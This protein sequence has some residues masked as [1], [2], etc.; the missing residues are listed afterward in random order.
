MHILQTGVN[1]EVGRE[2]LLFLLEQGHT[3]LATDVVPLLPDI[4]EKAEK[5]RSGSWKFQLLDC[6]DL[7]AID[8]ILEG[9]QPP[10]EGVIHYGAVSQPLGSNFRIVHNNN[11]VSSYNI[12]ESCASHGIN[13]VVQASSINAPGMGFAPENHITHD[14]LPINEECPM[15]PVSRRLASSRLTTLQEDPYSLSKASVPFMRFFSLS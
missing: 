12:L 9:A 2:Q 11:T 8:A 6:K 14:R 5:S 15:R 7:A 4:R 10:I 1:G 3:V 13:R